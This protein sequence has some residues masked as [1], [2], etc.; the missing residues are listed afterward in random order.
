M[1]PETAKFE[2]PERTI[3]GRIRVT[4]NVIA[5]GKWR[6]VGRNYRIAKCACAKKALKALK[7]ADGS[8]NST[9]NGAAG[10]V[11]KMG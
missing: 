2:K 4:V 6:G 10:G 8:G 7:G 5:K 1:E 3:D 9:A 11:S